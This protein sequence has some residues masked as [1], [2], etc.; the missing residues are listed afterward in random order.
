MNF[1]EANGVS[2]RYAVEG[3]GK[4]V[5]LIH[6]MG[7]SMESWGL[8][9]PILA[10]HRRVV[11][12]D[13]RGAGFSE[14]IRG[15][16]T[17]D[18]MTDDLI[19]LLDA[20]GIKEKIALGGTA[21]GGA[22]ALHTAFRFP[23]RIAAVAVTSPATFMPPENRAVTLARVDDFER[24]G[25]RVAFET[26]A[27]NGYAEELRGDRARFSA[28]RARWLGN[29]PASFAAVYRMLSNTDLTPE[30]PSIRCPVLVIGGEFDRGRPPYR[31][32]P[33]AKAIP[34]AKFKV[35][36]TGHY[37]GWQTPELVATEIGAFLDA[38]GA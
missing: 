23:D 8:V 32:E 33:I 9:A 3:A 1:T 22:I 4:P 6:E 17:I 18:T 16:L 30:L 27:N 12:Y 24:N 11:R 7:G 14:K 31:V 26:T 25:V 29:D 37:A 19:A 13:T 21:V 34:G 36:R 2:L 35:L 10:A 5:V 38:A 20:L 15:P 28:W